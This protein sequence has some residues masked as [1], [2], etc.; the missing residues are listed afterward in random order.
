ML[1]VLIKVKI[2]IQ[3]TLK[4]NKF[5]KIKFYFKIM[6]ANYYNL[7]TLRNANMYTYI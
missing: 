2:F 6:Y 4:L 1:K 5:L 7:I 3:L